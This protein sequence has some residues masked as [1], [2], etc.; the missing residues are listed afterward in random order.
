MAAPGQ[1]RLPV[2]LRRSW[3]GLNQAFRRRCAILGLT[4]DQYTALRTLVEG[5]RRGLTQTQLVE[6][7]SS[8]PNTIASLLNR[9]EANGW[10]QRQPHEADRRAHRLAVQSAGRRKFLQARRQARALQSRVLSVL[11]E[12]QRSEFLEAL[13]LIAEACHE[14]AEAIPRKG[15]LQR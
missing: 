10:I 8:D 5:D 9:M 14:S 11:P 4:P 15:S 1:R 12:R 13:A 6:A 7:M 3:Y 2:L